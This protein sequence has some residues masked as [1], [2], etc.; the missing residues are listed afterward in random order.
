VSRGPSPLPVGRDSVMAAVV[1]AAGR[2]FADRGL[3]QVSV[4]EIAAA[5]GVNHALVHRHFG[6]KEQVIH[7]VL[8]HEALLF[9]Q[10]IDDLAIDGR[11]ADL[12]AV[13]GSRERFWRVLAH[14]MLS[15]IDPTHLVAEN[16]NLRRLTDL[17]DRRT[18]KS[19]MSAEATV[20]AAAALALGWALFAPFLLSAT[21]RGIATPNSIHAEVE[22]I[23][24][25][26]LK[27]T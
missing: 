20:G 16:D 15:G 1:E 24:A 17:V 11:G 25:A 22:K 3:E 27:R 5:A 6:T 12:F 14:C 18:N 13:V 8:Q 7:A 21:D 26:L 2:L 19:G 10:Q 4:R 9:S 23:G